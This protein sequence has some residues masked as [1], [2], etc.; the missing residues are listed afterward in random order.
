MWP[1]YALICNKGNTEYH[2]VTEIKV[3]SK[4]FKKKK[5]PNWL[6]THFRTYSKTT[7]WG[8]RLRRKID[9][10]TIK[11]LI[12]AFILVGVIAVVVSFN[13]IANQKYL[14]STTTSIPSTTTKPITW[15]ENNFIETIISISSSSGNCLVKTNNQ[16]LMNSLYR[17]TNH[18]NSTEIDIVGQDSTKVLCWTLNGNCY[19]FSTSANKVTNHPI[20]SLNSLR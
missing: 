1:I 10:R 15:T 16:E 4:L 11:L 14:L 9:Q 20:K 7:T 18:Q 2:I 3:L 6:N 19:C 13:I 12:V 17:A 5:M 8:K